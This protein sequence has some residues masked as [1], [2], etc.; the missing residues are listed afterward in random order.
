MPSLPPS[1]WPADSGPG[2][3]SVGLALVPF[4]YILLLGCGSSFAHDLVSSTPA[5]RGL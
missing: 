4:R 5:C 3:L 1:C 2:L